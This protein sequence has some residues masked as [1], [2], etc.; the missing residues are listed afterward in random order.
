MKIKK[1]LYIVPFDVTGHILWSVLHAKCKR[2]FYLLILI[3]LICSQCLWKMFLL[4]KEINGEGKTESQG[5]G[6]LFGNF[7]IA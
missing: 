6:I 7:I 3:L 5:C 1:V 4:V 2:A